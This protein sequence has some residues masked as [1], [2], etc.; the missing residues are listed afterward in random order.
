MKERILGN[1]L[2]VSAVGL[3]CMGF[4]HAY[5]EPTEKKEAVRL[6]QKAAD[7][8][9]TLMRAVPGSIS[10]WCQIPGLR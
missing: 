8:G 3:G 9:S 1:G 6:I 5:G 4:S 10:H 2:K 7:M